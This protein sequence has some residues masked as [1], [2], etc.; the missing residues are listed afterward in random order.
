[1]DDVVRPC[2][3]ADET[4]WLRCRVLTFLPRTEPP[5]DRRSAAPTPAHTAVRV[6]RHVRPLRTAA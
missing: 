2:T 3:P 6:T 4:S 5:R 1:M